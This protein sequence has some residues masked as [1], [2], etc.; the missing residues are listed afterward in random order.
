V[1]KG[2]THQIHSIEF[3]QLLAF[4]RTPSVFKRRAS[5]PIG[6]HWTRK[7]FSRIV[8]ETPPGNPVVAVAHY[9]AVLSIRLLDE[10]GADKSRERS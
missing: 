4:G 1:S 5:G 3:R 7:W 8:P 10:V 2:G 9:D 6:S